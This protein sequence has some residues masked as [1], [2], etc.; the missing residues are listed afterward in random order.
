MK[1]D[2]EI[3][4][5]STHSKLCRLEARYEALR[6]MPSEDDELRTV[7]LRSLKRYINQFKEEIARFEALRRDGREI[8]SN[9]GAALRLMSERDVE[10][11]RKKLRELE[12]EYDAN[13]KTNDGDEHLRELESES[14]KRL[15][16]QLKEE[17]AR[18]EA[19]QPAR[20]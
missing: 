15:I 14:L 16:N 18:Y 10:N 12:S 3:E 1:L 4:L 11:T 9:S 2:S 8:S 19:H 13:E 7:T 5:A 17:I 20:G 6:K